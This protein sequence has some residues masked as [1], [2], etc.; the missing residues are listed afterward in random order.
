MAARK[1]KIELDKEWRER[2]SATKLIQR[3]NSNA[4][5][6]LEPRMTRDQI[7]CAEILLKKVVPDLKAI[8]HSGPDGQQLQIG[9]V[10][11]RDITPPQ[12]K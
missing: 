10:Q 11:F 1:N 4:L 3:L 2:I 7:K 8:E 12:S 5:G 6:S 9:I